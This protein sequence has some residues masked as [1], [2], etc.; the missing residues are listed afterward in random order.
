MLLIESLKQLPCFVNQQLEVSTFDTGL[1][2]TV[3]K[4]ATKQGSFVAKHFQQAQSCQLEADIQQLLATQ[5]LSPTVHFTND[6]WLVSHFIDLPLLEN[7]ELNELGKLSIAVTALSGFHQVL[8][9]LANNSAARF[10]DIHPLNIAKVIKGLLPQSLPSPQ[11]S[12][13]LSNAVISEA[14]A[15]A[16]QLAAIDDQQNIL[17]HGDL[18]FANIFVDLNASN[19]EGGNLQ[20][21]I[22]QSFSSYLIDFEAVSLAPVSYDLAMVFAINQLP[23]EL[24]PYGVKTY[25]DFSPLTLGISTEKVTRYLFLASVINT[26]WFEQTY[27]QRGIAKYLSLAK[28]HGLYTTRVFFALS[29]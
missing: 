10:A 14:I 26:L 7:I 6:H 27:N 11:S 3:F 2:N 9:G 19:N 12:K 1:N 5:N 8:N 29:S 13:I 21:S 25:Q 16:E 24:I 20:K 23:L 15:L 22:K 18:N 28:Q 17:V 4:V